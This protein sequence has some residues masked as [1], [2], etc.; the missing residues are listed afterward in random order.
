MMG[1]GVI[2]FKVLSPFPRKTCP[3]L[4]GPTATRSSFPSPLTSV[5]ITRGLRVQCR[6]AKMSC[7]PCPIDRDAIRSRHCKFQNPVP[8]EMH[9]RARAPCTS[10]SVLENDIFCASA[11][12]L[13]AK[14]RT[15][16]IADTTHRPIVSEFQAG[17]SGDEARILRLT[18]EVGRRKPILNL[19]TTTSS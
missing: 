14:Q 7:H 6:S 10:M 3:V 13:V 5:V 11:G 17:S 12:T 15:M 16:Y 2:G 4:L 9:R 18:Y 19:C 1:K 8:I